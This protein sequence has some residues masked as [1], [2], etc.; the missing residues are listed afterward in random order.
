[1]ADQ[2]ELLAF[3]LERYRCALLPILKQTDAADRGSGEDREGVAVLV[4]GLIIEADVSAHDREV[5]RAA[6][7]GDAFDATDELAHDIGP[8]RVAE[9]E[10][11]SDRQRLRPDRAEV[12][13]GL[14]DRLLPAL[15]GVGLAIA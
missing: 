10:A 3:R 8:L 4:L 15:D 12:A 2:D 11:V 1:M 6:R 5:E 13:V 14:G 9:V 7:F